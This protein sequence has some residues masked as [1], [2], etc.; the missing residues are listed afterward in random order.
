MKNILPFVLILLAVFFCEDVNAQAVVSNAQRAREI[1]YDVNFYFLNLDIETTYTISGNVLVQAVSLVNNLDTFALELANTL[2]VDSATTSVNGGV[3]KKATVLRNGSEL[4]LLLPSGASSGQTVS[5]QVYYHGNPVVSD[6]F[7]APFPSGFFGESN[8]IPGGPQAYSASPPYNSS[9]WWPCKQVLTDKADSSWFFI[10]TDSVNRGISNGLLTNTVKLGAKTEYKWKS[11]YPIDFYLISFVVRPCTE[12]T[13]YWHPAGRTDSLLLKGYNSSV[14]D[15]VIL[16]L[17]TKLFGLYYFYKEKLGLATVDLGGG[18]ENQTCISFG[19]V[20]DVEPH[21]VA[22]QWFG[23][24]VTCGSYKDILL[25]EGFARWCESVYDEFTTLGD[26]NAARISHF[27]DNLSTTPVYGSTMD[28]TSVEGVYLN[29]AIYYDKAAMVINSLRFTIN[30]DSIFFL[31]LRNYQSQFSGKTALGTDLR[32]VME[33]TSGIDLTDFFNQW[34]YGRGGPTFNI[35]WNQL[36]NNNLV[37]QITETTNSDSTPLYKTPLEIEVQRTQGDT[38]VRLFIPANV[39][40][41][42]FHCPG[43]IT[44]FVVDPNQWITNGVGTVTYDGTLTGI[45]NTDT[46]YSYLIAPNPA[47]NSFRITGNGLD[48]LEVKV[49]D[50]LGNL[51]YYNNHYH[52]GESI[53]TSTLAKGIYFVHLDNAQSK[54]VI[55]INK[56]VIN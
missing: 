34:Y 28:T 20:G 6:G 8:I 53:E 27:T 7:S 38:T 41:F 10:T 37:L 22:H 14:P 44:G 36:I 32:A 29:Q 13:A 2:P 21:E 54:N 24:N 51:Y 9:A 42:V 49:Y 23:D 16:N 17:Y 25:N 5:V 31:G 56:L 3:F 55:G 4:N 47:S 52:Q 50:V 35:G 46:S 39:S 19:T 48:L 30:N 26:P 18:M 11:K 45:I 15:T 12:T 40:N 43:N 33:T 1:E